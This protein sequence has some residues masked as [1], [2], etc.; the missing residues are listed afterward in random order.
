MQLVEQGKLD[1]DADVNTYLTTFKIPA[2]YPEPITLAHLLTHTAGFEE[3][4]SNGATYVASAAQL[5][6]LGTSLASTLPARIY[7]AGSRIAYSNYGAA[8]AGHLIEQASGMPFEKYMAEHV[9][10]PLEMGNSTFAQPLP[11]ALATIAA[12]GYTVDE[13]GAASPQ[14]F[15]Y[16]QLAPASAFST[17]ASD[18]ANFMIAVRACSP[19]T[20][21]RQATLRCCS[22][23]IDQSKRTSGC[24]G[25]A[26]KRARCSRSSQRWGCLLRPSSPGRSAP[27]LDCSV[28]GV[29]A[30]TRRSVGHGF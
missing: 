9:L 7:P 16:L 26:C 1:L 11:S 23:V 30:R 21:M 18:V 22:T 10:R 13:E 24:R 19:S 27:Q 14:A 3:H 17:T 5:Q 8:L 28:G 12:T 25:T 2:T 20:R 6:P 15:E 29:S 4:A